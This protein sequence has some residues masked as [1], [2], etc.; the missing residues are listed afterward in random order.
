MLY[1]AITGVSCKNYKWH[2]N[3]Q[4]GENSGL[5]EL[6]LPVHN[7][8]IKV[9]SF[10]DTLRNINNSAHVEHYVKHS[11]RIHKL[12]VGRNLLFRKFPLKRLTWRLQWFQLRVKNVTAENDGSFLSFQ[13]PEKS[14]KT[15]KTEGL[16]NYA[17]RIPKLLCYATAET[18]E[19][20]LSS[21]RLLRKQIRIKY[22]E[23]QIHETT[24]NR[25]IEKKGRGVNKDIWYDGHFRTEECRQNIP[26]FHIWVI[27]SM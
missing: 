11:D 15:V 9:Q 18:G 12:T 23:R 25:Q 1:R 24:F 8:N 16:F 13:F 3:T 17:V 19:F 2:I 26:S 20:V 21:T 6:N 5:L 22:T 4:C 27:L 7:I 10:K 14:Q